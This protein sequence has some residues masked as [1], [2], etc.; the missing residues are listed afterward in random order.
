MTSPRLVM[1]NIKISI[2]T[3]IPFH[4][5]NQKIEIDNKIYAVKIYSTCPWLINVTGLRS[6]ADISSIRSFLTAHVLSPS[7]IKR[8]HVDSMF[9]SRRLS[10]P[11]QYDMERI[12][13]FCRDHCKQDYFVSYNPEITTSK[14][15][16]LPRQ[17]KEKR[18]K[19]SSKIRL[20]QVN[21]REVKPPQ[22]TLFY[23]GAVTVMGLRSVSQIEKVDNLI[24]QIYQDGFKRTVNITN[25]T[26]SK[27]IFKS[28]Y[29]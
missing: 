21:L 29:R 28:K 24:E 1:S 23:T 17:K 10:N 25:N 16:L 27:D 9:A 12:A 15:L 14:C 7:N 18:N 6:L 4:S 26:K 22:I 5:C 11:V 8:V 2:A 13:Q 19:T 20:K 3:T